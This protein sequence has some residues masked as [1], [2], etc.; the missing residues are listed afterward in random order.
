MRKRPKKWKESDRRK[1]GC[2]MMSGDKKAQ[3]KRGE[4]RV[5]RVDKKVKRGKERKAN[6]FS[7][8]LFVGGFIF[9]DNFIGGVRSSGR[10]GDDSGL[11]LVRVVVVVLLAL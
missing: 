11:D 3:N 5:T 2:L 7:K 10:S 6:R 1:D 4:K 8:K 9:E